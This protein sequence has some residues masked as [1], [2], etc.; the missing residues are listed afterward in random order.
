ATAGVAR[1]A[2]SGFPATTTAGTTGSFAVTAKNFDGTTA[3]SY[4]GTV[5]LSSTDSQAVLPPDYTFTAA[6]NGT[7]TFSA[8][9]ATAGS[10]SITV[11]DATAGIT[12]TQGSILVQSAA[13]SAFFIAGFPSPVSSGTAGSFTVT[14]KDPYGNVVTG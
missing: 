11:S 9:L 10:Q 13:A 14:A 2:V 3:T 5:H 4:T 7:H 1:L 12:G 8:T 6:D